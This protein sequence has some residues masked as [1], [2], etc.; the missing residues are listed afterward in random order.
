MGGGA[1][2]APRRKGLALRCRRDEAS[3]RASERG[4]S[5]IEVLVA[6]AILGAAVTVI[7]GGFGASVHN[8]DLTARQAALEVEVRGLADYLRREDVP[9]ATCNPA[10]VAYYTDELNR[11]KSANVRV[12]V[13]NVSVLAGGTYVSVVTTCGGN[14]DVQ[15]IDITI[16]ENRADP[17]SA[18]ASV[19]KRKSGSQ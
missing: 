19:V 4:V 10:P 1:G 8:S 9:M 7:I 15:R 11:R 17:V 2:L 12:T 18:K 16:S 14:L 6:V 3:S 5:L 13:D